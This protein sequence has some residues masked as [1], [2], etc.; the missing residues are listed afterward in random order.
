MQAKDTAAARAEYNKAN[1]AF[2]I[3]HGLFSEVRVPPPPLP[4]LPSLTTITTHHHHH[5]PHPP[6]RRHHPQQDL[7]FPELAYLSALDEAKAVADGGTDLTELASHPLPSRLPSNLVPPL[8]KLTRKL[9]MMY[10]AVAEKTGRADVTLKRW[11]AFCD[12]KS[13]LVSRATL[14]MHFNYVV[15]FLFSWQISSSSIARNA[16][17]Q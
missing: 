16:K 17:V 3:L 11:R 12:S 4:S 7:D 8:G 10:G 14:P 6:S 1:R 2:E 13:S 15:Q 9:M 5:H